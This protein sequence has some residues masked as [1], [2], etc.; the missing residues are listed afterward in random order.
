MEFY[1]YFPK[2]RIKKKKIE[3]A[4]LLQTLYRWNN[5]KLVA[6]ALLQAF[7]WILFLVLRVEG[8]PLAN[9]LFSVAGPQAS[10]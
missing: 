6:E 7:F 2:I 10:G 5:Q 4:R 9:Q 1:R 8:A 3:F